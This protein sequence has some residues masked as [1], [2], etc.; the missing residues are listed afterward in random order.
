MTDVGNWSHVQ[1][2]AAVTL[3][4]V[5]GRS[6]LAQ[7]KTLALPILP[8]ITRSMPTFIPAANAAAAGSAGT[9]AAGGLAT[10][11]KL[12]A[13]LLLKRPLAGSAVAAAGG[14]GAAA[15]AIRTVPAGPESAATAAAAAT[16]SSG[17]SSGRTG[18]F[19]LWGRHFKQWGDGLGQGLRGAVLTVRRLAVGQRAMVVEQLDTA[20]AA[21]AT[22]ARASGGA[23][24]RGWF[25]RRNSSYGGTRQLAAAQVGAAGAVMVLP[26]PVEVAVGPSPQWGAV[27][28]SSRHEVKVHGFMGGFGHHV[29]R[30]VL[31]LGST[32]HKATG[33][34]AVLAS[35]QMGYFM[36]RHSP[37]Q[38]AATAALGGSQ[39]NLAHSSSSGNLL[40]QQQQQRT[41]ANQRS[42][43]APSLA[44]VAAAAAATSGSEWN[45]QHS[46][47]GG[48]QL[49]AGDQQEYC[50]SDD[51]YGSSC[52]GSVVSS[53][54]SGRS[55]GVGRQVLN[56]P[57]PRLSWGRRAS[58]AVIVGK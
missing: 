2:G 44:L 9:S 43:S 8:A 54:V 52:A 50:L 55:S 28:S 35:K 32:A 17:A 36:N 58:H 14:A 24:R 4:A 47:A 30:H 22:A 31:W 45:A 57:A 20:A 49:V 37:G 11:L 39:Y 53:S 51:L 23:G 41:L 26:N 40:L 38:A 56:L 19:V 42:K 6:T 33:A 21:Q 16:S 18:G 48:V 34:I 7:L 3:L 15:A 27:S 12:P 13:A 46:A 25:G 29:G 5:T 10:T 1:A